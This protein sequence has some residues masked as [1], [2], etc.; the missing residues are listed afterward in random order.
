MLVWAVS[1]AMV[2]PMLMWYMAGSESK[3][4]PSELLDTV[5]IIRGALLVTIMVLVVRQMLGR[6]VDPVLEASGGVDPLA[7]TFSSRSGFTHRGFIGADSPVSAEPDAED[8]VS[9]GRLNTTSVS[10]TV[11]RV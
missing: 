7:G 4:P 5:L 1:E 3:A 10:A 9:V 6:A 8:R 11:E 2:W